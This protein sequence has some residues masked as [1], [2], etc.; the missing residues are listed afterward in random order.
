[1]PFLEIIL[2]LTI[3]IAL[4]LTGLIIYIR[5]CRQIRKEKIEN[6]PLNELFIIFG[7]YGGLLLLFISCLVYPNSWSGM[8]SLGIFY[9]IFI[10][11]IVMGRIAYRHNKTK[12]NSKYHNWTY[13]SGLLYFLITPVTFLILFFTIVNW[14]KNL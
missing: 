10:A 3:Y 4:P 13:N 5:L 8:A 12:T 7:T 6:A 2:A 11:P 14:Q 9:L 1:M